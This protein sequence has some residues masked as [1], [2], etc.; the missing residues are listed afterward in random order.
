[1]ARREQRS[2]TND[3]GEFHVLF[4]ARQTAPS[5]RN[6]SCR[7][8]PAFMEACPRDQRETSKKPTGNQRQ[9]ADGRPYDLPLASFLASSAFFSR[10]HAQSCLRCFSLGCCRVSKPVGTLVDRLH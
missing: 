8:A 6:Q 10:L 9:E 4:P 5:L 2:R 3:P 1:M 7:Q